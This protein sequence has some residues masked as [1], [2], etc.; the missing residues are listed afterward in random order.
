[1]YIY[2]KRNAFSLLQKE[3]ILVAFRI[4]RLREL[5]KIGPWNL[6]ENFLNIGPALW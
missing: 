1:M 6:M 5:K 3:A 4:A 2:V